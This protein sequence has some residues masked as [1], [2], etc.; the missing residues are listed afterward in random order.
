MKIILVA[1]P[2]TGSTS[3]GKYFHAVMP[4]YKVFLEPFN[5]IKEPPFE[6]DFVLKNEN[7]FVKQLFRQI[8]KKYSEIPITDF[9][10]MVLNDFD[11][12]VFL[13]RRNVEKQS[14]SYSA[15]L[16]NDNWFD[17]YIFDNKKDNDKFDLSLIILNDV[18]TEI[19]DY[20]IKK[21]IKMF[22]YEDLY[23]DKNNMLNFLDE[24]NCIYDEDI[25]NLFLSSE[26]KYRSEKNTKTII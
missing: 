16:I 7:V 9:Y 13:S 4:T 25:Y 1:E 24:I 2:R 23:F 17:S 8:P 21:N 22:Y 20:V 18:K 10:D 11:K 26:K 6:Y 5:K 19:N 15:A 14:E 3:I 12:I